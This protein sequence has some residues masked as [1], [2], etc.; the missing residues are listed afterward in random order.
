M[1]IA[2]KNQW[3]WI[4]SIMATALLAIVGSWATF[5]GGVSRAD[6]LELIKHHAPY[7]ED[8]K[9]INTRM[10]SIETGVKDNRKVLDEIRTELWKNRRPE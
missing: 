2:E 10:Q 8:R 7:V 9:D 5:G 6:T 1:T 4:S 3:K